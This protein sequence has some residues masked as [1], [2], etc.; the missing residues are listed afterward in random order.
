MGEDHEVVF[1]VAPDA[2]GAKEQAK[3]K[4]RGAGRGHVDAV[5]RLDVIDGYQVAVVADGGEQDQMVLDSYN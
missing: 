1:V 3:A 5:Q 2:A 4:W